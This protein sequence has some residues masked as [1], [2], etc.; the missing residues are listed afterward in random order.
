MKK[1]R[2]IFQTKGK[3]KSPET[4]LDETE[5]SDLSDR[6][7]NSDHKHGHQGQ[8]SMNKVKMSTKVKKIQKSTKR[9]S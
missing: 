6:F 5:I 4:A 7:Q 1:Q 3:A 2:N 9:K 8:E